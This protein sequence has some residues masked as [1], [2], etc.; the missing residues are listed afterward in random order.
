[1]ELFKERIELYRTSLEQNVDVEK[2]YPMLQQDRAIS[3]EEISQIETFSPKTAKVKKLLD[4]FLSKD[5]AA[6][7]SLFL[8]LQKFYQHILT[9]MFSDPVFPISHSNQQGN[10]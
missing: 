8:V 6:L 10:F 5:N 2:L 3:A 7:Q 9:A 4:I 1:M